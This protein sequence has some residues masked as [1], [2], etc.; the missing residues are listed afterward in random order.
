MP[1]LRQMLK[2][3]QGERGRTQKELDSI[4]EVIAALRK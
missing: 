1:N 4:D 3:L 2:E